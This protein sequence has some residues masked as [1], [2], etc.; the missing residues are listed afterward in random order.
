MSWAGRAWQGG[1][2][3]WPMVRLEDA[4][5]LLARRGAASRW[6]ALDELRLHGLVAE[7]A[8]GVLC[9]HG[10]LAFDALA[11]APEA[12]RLFGLPRA[13]HAAAE[14][15]L[16]L[17]VPR[18]CWASAFACAALA[19][20]TVAKAGL[21]LVAGPQRVRNATGGVECGVDGFAEP[22]GDEAAGVVFELQ[23]VQHCTRVDLLRKKMDEKAAGVVKA[24]AVARAG[25]EQQGL[26]ALAQATR[27]FVV[28]IEVPSNTPLETHRAPLVR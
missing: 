3:A 17:R 9:D 21:R 14:R 12:E 5:H 15:P 13:R 1:E 11:G 16:R 28:T 2:E 22:I 7:Q 23:C 6:E 19:W 8:L 25:P 4:V 20:R 10:R 18:R 27:L 24:A 26:P